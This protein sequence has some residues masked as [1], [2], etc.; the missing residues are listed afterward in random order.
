GYLITGSRNV[1]LGYSSGRFET[2]N[3]KLYIANSDT[4]TP[5]LYG[6]FEK[7][8]L[9]IN[10]TL[11]TE[12]LYMTEGATNGYLL[13]SNASGKAT[14]VN[15]ISLFNNV[16]SISGSNIY[17]NN[18]FNV[19]I[20][21]STPS[22]KLHVAGNIA[23]NGGRL[24]MVNPNLNVFI[25]EYVGQ[26][27]TTGYNNNIMGFNA[28]S[29]ST[30]G[31][32]NVAIGTD[33]LMLNTTGNL[34]TSIG[35]FTLKNGTSV[36]STVAV[37]YAAGFNATGDRN[38]FLG[39]AS[40]YNETGSHKLYIDNSTT[41]SPLL[42]GEFDKNR[43]TINDTLIS[44]SFRI[45]SGKI[46]FINT[47]KSVFI[48]EEAGKVDDL[49]DNENTF[50]GYQTAKTN[51]TGFENT[52]IGSEA[53]L[54]NS[55]GD[56]NVAIGNE[57]MYSNVGGNYNVSI[58]Y[59][60]G[61][62]GDFHNNT[63]V[64]SFTGLN[65]HGG[66]N[67]FLGYRA[68]ENETGS[69]KLCISNSNTVTPLLYGEFDIKRLTV[70]DTLITKR[71]KING[72][73]ISFINS[74]RSV[75]I[76]EAAGAVDDLTAND[77]VLIGY[78]A[79]DANTTGFDNIALGTEALGSNDTGSRNVA[80]GDSAL[81]ANTLGFLN[82]AIGTKALNSG[83][84]PVGNVAIGQSALSV[85]NGSSNTAIGNSAGS[86]STGTGNTFIGTSAGQNNTGSS[87]VFLG[88]DAGANSGSQS[89]KLYIDN[90]NTSTPLIFGDFS[91]NNVG[92][93]TSSPS[94]SL[95]VAGSFAST[96]KN[97]MVLGTDDPDGSA[98]VWRFTSNGGNN[99]LDLPA[100][101]SCPGRIY[102]LLNQTGNTYNIT[103]YTNLSG[104]LNTTISNSG[105][106]MLMSDGTGWF[107]IK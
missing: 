21:T 40:G 67:V 85:N 41:S 73:S 44:K 84:F 47:G 55:W 33:A 74:G 65:N 53:M 38:V 57:S 82:V 101:S 69:N 97:S 79:G 25:G 17:N 22:E 62:Y 70:N 20:G 11:V 76:G 24:A 36:D 50:I 39:Y 95:V 6:E 19:G 37:G 23:I 106:L 7:N 93:N 49:T 52:A 12:R 29:S 72:G 88:I 66:S 4:S 8:K 2:G 107:Q 80:I 81:A 9:T 46:S 31:Y 35:D 102:L 61:R 1:L 63:F 3:D 99:S 34:N 13:K 71:M 28:L 59:Q 10:D 90:S 96:M 14:W 92:I 83:A 45:N 64:G 104:S 87:N 5:L 16:W 26:A 32:N 42:Y 48:G 60:S 103:S 100:A 89:N 94:S 43:L 91:S 68:G 30:T 105:S 58:G 77:N 56:G 54:S 15:P 75:F 78:H 86:N 98:M 51:V 27:I 18:L